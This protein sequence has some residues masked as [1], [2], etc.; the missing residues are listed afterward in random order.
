MRP[1]KEETLVLEEISGLTVYRNLSFT[2]YFS[3]Y[4]RATDGSVRVAT[5]S[6]DMSALEEIHRLMPFSV[7][8][9]APKYEDAAKRFLRRFPLYIVYVVEELHT[10]CIFFEGSRK[11]LIGSQN[12]FTPTSG[13]E[14]L[15]VELRVSEAEVR[16]FKALAFGFPNAR[17]LRAPYEKKDIKF[18]ED[19]LN[20]VKDHPYLPCHIEL[21]YWRLLSQ[22]DTPDRSTTYHYIYL[23]LEYVVDGISTYLAF[24]R[25]YQHCGELSAEALQYL[26]DRF[27]PRCQVYTFLDKGKELSSTAPFKDQFAKYHPIARDNKAKQAYYFDNR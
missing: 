17:Y 18:Y 22:K 4:S 24:D 19:N 9:V 6:F 5:Y 7:F 13:F 8:Y 16:N 25:H 10:K 11:A 14:E 2:N 23:V 3:N 20:G 1:K 27:A 12:L 15:G 21:E 26:C